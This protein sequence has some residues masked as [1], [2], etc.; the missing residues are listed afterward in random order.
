M[1]TLGSPDSVQLVPLQVIVP[2]VP[3][4]SRAHG[5]GTGCSIG[6]VGVLPFVVVVTTDRRPTTGS[7][8]ISETPCGL[9]GEHRLLDADD[10]VDA[11]AGARHQ[12]ARAVV[13][14]AAVVRDLE[15]LDGL[16]VRRGEVDHLDAVLGHLAGED[17][18]V[19]P[20]HR[21]RRRPARY[22]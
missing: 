12:D 22:P 16:A 19:R 2:C 9:I 13:H 6:V 18:R 14:E 3:M 20:C 17:R 21:R 4:V 15:G 11:V 10:Q 8:G 7:V 1:K 5:S